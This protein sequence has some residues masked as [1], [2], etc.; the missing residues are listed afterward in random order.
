MG[1]ST[2]TTNINSG[3]GTQNTSNVVGTQNNHFVNS[4][5]TAASH[6]HKTLW[7]AVG[8]VGASHT[9]EQQFGRGECL[10]GTRVRALGVIGNWRTSRQRESPIFW[11][12]GATGVGKTAIAMSVA[13]SCEEDNLISS[14]FFFRSDSRRNNPSALVLSISRDLVVRF[15][16]LQTSINQRISDDPAILGARMEVQFR[17]LVLQPFLDHSTRKPSW[18]LSKH[19]RRS[20]GVPGSW[21]GPT[22]L[23]GRPRLHAI[24]CILATLACVLPAAARRSS[25][26]ATL[27]VLAMSL[28]IVAV[29]LAVI[30]S[31]SSAQ[32]EKSG[33]VIIDGLD[34]CSDEDTQLRIISTIESAF[35]RSPDFPLRFLICSRPEAWLQEVF[36][37]RPLRQI[38]KVVVLDDSFRPKADIRQYYIHHF[39]AMVNNP[40]YKGVRFPNPWPSEAD[41]EDLVDLSCG[42]FVYAAT[43]VKFIKF[44]FRH[45]I[46]QLQVILRNTPPRRPGA[47]PYQELDALYDHILSVNPDYEEILPILSAI[48]ILPAYLEP[49]PAHIELLLGLSPGQVTL[50]L[51]PMYSVLDI[52]GSGDAIYPFHNSFRD[53]LIDASRS[54]KFHIDTSTQTQV[55]ARQ[56]LQNLT[57]EKVRTYSS[58]PLY[59]EDTSYFTKWIDLCT[60]IKPTRELLND[61]WNVDL[62]SAYLVDKGAS[63]EGM[64]HS[65]IP[66]VKKYLLY[67]QHHYGH[68]ITENEKKEARD[69]AKAGT[70]LQ[71]RIVRYLRPGGDQRLHNVADGDP[72]IRGTAEDLDVADL[73]E[74]LVYKFESYPRCFHLEWPPGVPLQD[75]VLYWVVDRATRCPRNTRLNASRPNSGQVLHLTDCHCDLSG[76]NQSDD[77]WHI[78]YQEACLRLVKAF[79]S[80]FE[81]LALS[82]KN[83]HK[84]TDELE[85]TFQ[86]LALTSLLKHCRPDT[87]LF[88]LCQTFFI[89][90]KGCLLMEVGPSN[91]EKGK[92]NL[93]GW[94]EAFPDK[95]DEERQALKAQVV[96]LP[97]CQWKQNYSSEVAPSSWERDRSDDVD[98]AFPFCLA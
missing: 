18:K 82:G 34:E 97:W 47:S 78:A 1:R 74:G 63:W 23:G 87:E 21:S 20:R 56:W 31:H 71:S 54:H 10:E 48:I 53:Y 38:S 8:D 52:G 12:T 37:A 19:R 29:L 2:V 15:P 94:I 90:A 73:V 58:N 26:T 22:L 84:T 4:F 59:G 92:T 62:A 76:G 9:A 91:G 13:K 96:T 80:L 72:P 30:P 75:D 55:L 79:V 89:L 61:L 41:L 60:S 65:L 66:W 32:T 25:L 86:N 36:A 7:E 98:Q 77:P 11:L 14:F 27:C 95:F 5:N 16:S 51:R 49:T 45:P 57:T 40:K 24:T 28:P 50:T 68:G 17:E 70:S 35:R 44:G 46:E 85:C 83:D 43:A 81:E 39:Q 67:H 6:P 69:R 64:F 42:Q 33:L 93:L 88:S 3:S